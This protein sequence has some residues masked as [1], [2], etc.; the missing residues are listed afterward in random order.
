VA[1]QHIPPIMGSVEQLALACFGA[2]SS[3]DEA[4]TTAARTIFLKWVIGFFLDETSKQDRV[5]DAG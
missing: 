2:T 4:A 5:W 1:I 3:D